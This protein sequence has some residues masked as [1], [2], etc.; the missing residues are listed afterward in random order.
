MVVT[1]AQLM[2]EEL[3]FMVQGGKHEGYMWRTRTISG[4]CAGKAQYVYDVER[5]RFSA[6]T[7][8]VRYPSIEMAHYTAAH[9]G[10]LSG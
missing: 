2:V 8:G 4:I 6:S 5:E 1:K 7:A 10:T 3:Q 9:Q